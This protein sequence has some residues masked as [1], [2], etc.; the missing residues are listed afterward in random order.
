MKVSITQYENPI[1]SPYRH[2]NRP[3]PGDSAVVI[4][5]LVDLELESDSQQMSWN[6]NHRNLFRYWNRLQCRNRFYYN[7]G[8]GSTSGI[9]STKWN[10][11]RSHC[12]LFS[13]SCVQSYL[14]TRYQNS[15]KWGMPTFLGS[16]LR[17]KRAH[18]Y[19]RLMQLLKISR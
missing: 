4:P 2:P 3:A 6:W 11:S 5:F 15:E 9:S 14:R 18:I 19:V 13:I 12:A 17:I 8:I 7:T 1:G 10:N 16:I